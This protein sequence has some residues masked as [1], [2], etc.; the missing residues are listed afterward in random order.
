MKKINKIC[1]FTVLFTLPNLVHSLSSEL[2][3]VCVSETTVGWKKNEDFLNLSQWSGSKKFVLKPMSGQKAVKISES[4][5]VENY[6]ENDFNERDL[7][8]S[9]VIKQGFRQHYCIKQGSASSHLDCYLEVDGVIHIDDEPALFVYE[10]T[11]G[12]IYFSSLYIGS[13]W[14]KLNTQRFPDIPLIDIGEC[15]DF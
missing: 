15:V 10:T 6:G 14:L 1:L 9:H 7:K 2:N 8:V 12:R 5:H 11:S 13:P 4:P 3:Y